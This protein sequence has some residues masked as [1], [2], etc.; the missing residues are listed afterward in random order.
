M[1]TVAAGAVAT[2]SISTSAQE[3]F[4]D[5]EH[6]VERH[7]RDDNRDRRG[8][9][10][11][12]GAV[13][14]GLGTLLFG[15]I[16]SNEDILDTDTDRRRYVDRHYRPYSYN[17]RGWRRHRRSRERY[18]VREQKTYRHRDHRH[19]YWEIRCNY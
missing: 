1:A 10:N 6:H 13:A 2:C 19:T 12:G 3:R 15:A 16:I 7:D 14:I 9:I 8:G 18:C 4:S 17:D 11:T 5:R